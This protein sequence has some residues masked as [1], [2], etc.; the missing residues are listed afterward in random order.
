MADAMNRDDEPTLA[1]SLDKL[2]RADADHLTSARSILARARKDLSHGTFPDVGRQRFFEITVFRVRPGHSPAFEAAA[3][4]YGAAT[5]RATPQASYRVYE[6][7]AGMPSPT[8]LVISSVTSYG[9]FDKVMAD[10]QAVMKSF[11][12]EEM[13][14][15]EKF[16][17]E[18]LLNTETIRFRVDP[19]MSYMPPEVRAQDPGF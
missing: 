17:V 14:V 15:L 9:A 10:D 16:S 1:A 12:P 11:T 7:M 6:V 5:T 18:G 2:R 19:A 3:K 4:A 8:Y 13:T